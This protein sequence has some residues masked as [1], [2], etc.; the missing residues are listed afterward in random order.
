MRSSVQPLMRMW[1]RM[2]SPVVKR[3]QGIVTCG[4]TP[5]KLA[6]TLCFGTAFGTIPL[7]WGTSIICLILAKILRLNHVALQSVNYLL[8]PVHLALLIPFFKLGT[9]LFP[10]GPVLPD[11]QLS[12]IVHSPGLITLNIFLW[13]T[14]KAVAVWLMTVIPIAL[15]AYLILRATV[16]RETVSINQC[17]YSE[18]I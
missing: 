16:L 5:Q 1:Q 2:V 14:L 12:A 8:W 17:N 7:V 15:L 3:A 11:H 6:M 10:W 18:D 9:L 4:L 13:L